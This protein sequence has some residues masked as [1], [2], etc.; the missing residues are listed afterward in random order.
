M[1][2]LVKL[3]FALVPTA[4]GS[5]IIAQESSTEK[6]HP[7]QAEIIANTRFI[8]NPGPN[9]ILKESGPEAWDEKSC[10]TAGVLK[11]G[12]TYYLYYH[13]IGQGHG[14]RTGVATAS[15]PLGPWKKY[16]KNPIIPGPCAKILK[17]SHDK[18]YAWY[19]NGESP[20]GEINLASAS[21]PLGPWV[22]YEKNPI[23][24]NVG[25]VSGVVKVKGT[26][27]LY[28]E[29]GD[30]FLATAQK[31]E[32]PWEKYSGPAV[33][34]PASR[35]L[36]D[37]V[38]ITE[39]PVLKGDIG[40]WDSSRY[41]PGGGYSEGSV[42][43][44]DGVF[45]LFYTGSQT[46]PTQAARLES[47]GYAFSFDGYNFI[48]HPKNPIGPREKNPDASSFSEVQVLFQPPFYY[49]YHTLRYESKG[50]WLGLTGDK[51]GYKGRSIEDIGVQ[52]FATERQFRLSMPLMNID[53]LPAAS[54]SS[55]K[56][57]PPLCLEQTKDLAVTVKCRYDKGISAGLRV[58][59]Q[60]SCDGLAYDTEELYVFD[61][62]CRAAETVSKTVEL[63]PKVMFIKVIVENLDS[64]YD[65]TDVK[66]T[67]TL[68][69]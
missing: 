54:A 52:I 67:A 65:V 20:R 58:H 25:Y 63:Q 34:S 40:A 61:L 29:A 50:G 14:Y 44:H 31:P 3:L 56:D 42:L 33:D 64:S 37:E 10:E 11:D 30:I 35:A 36:E 18:Y 48:K 8:Q 68:G 47:I 12:Y 22:P 39:N 51:T 23:L 27:F 28:H 62:P 55:L 2:H 6:P 4:C 59:I 32:G 46:C 24:K 66:V 43:Y 41:F 26:Y 15:H 9:P 45:H 49:A 16:E 38:K 69:S 13:A 7:A 17:E 60:A 21:H 53:I 5:E 57:C 1:K 19:Q